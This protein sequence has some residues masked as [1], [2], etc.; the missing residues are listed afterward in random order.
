MEM[1]QIRHALAVAQALSFT[2]AATDCNISQPAMTKSI[3]ALE[4]ELGGSLFHRDGKRILVSDFG[5]SMLA[6]LQRIIDEAQAAKTLATNNRLLRQ[7]PIRVGVLSTIGHVRL[8]PFLSQFQASHQRVEL[9]LEEGSLGAIVRQLEAGELDIAILNPLDDLAVRFNVTALYSERY[10]VVVAPEHRLASAVG[11][12]LRD[13]S[14]E[15][16][17]D[18]LACEMREMVLQVCGQKGIELY[19]RFRSE[20]EEWIQAMVLARIGFAFMPEYSVTLP[21][22][23]ARPLIEPEMRRSIVMATMPG[24]PHSPAVSAIVR[25]AQ[26]FAWPQ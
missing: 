9:T 21:G 24:R 19:A 15:L 12:G 7:A 1:S 20:R 23:V 11:I 14:G 16:Y 25:S 8:S 22:L 2:R 26:A 5:R 4:D 18:R 3:K 17:V 10:V 6:H 13:L